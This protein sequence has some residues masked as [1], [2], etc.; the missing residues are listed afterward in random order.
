MSSSYGDALRL[1]NKAIDE[2]AKVIRDHSSVN[3]RIKVSLA[4]ALKGLLLLYGLGY[5]SSDDITYLASLAL[6]NNILDSNLFA[7]VAY[8]NVKL[9]SR[10][11]VDP[12]EAS[13][14]LNK[15]LD[16][17]VKKDQ[18]LNKQMKLFRY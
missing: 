9:L 13:E 5:I 1:F 12:N 11:K 18:Y 14:I 10:E 8:L 3:K 7:E 15:I 2:L 6:D 17:A 16:K 4:S